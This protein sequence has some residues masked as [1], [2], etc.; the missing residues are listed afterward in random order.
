MREGWRKGVDRGATAGRGALAWVECARG[1]C[2]GSVEIKGVSQ[3]AVQVDCGQMERRRTLAVPADSA[4]EVLIRSKL[5][6]ALGATQEDHEDQGLQLTSGV[7]I[8]L[9]LS[10]ARSRMAEEKEGKTESRS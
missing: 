2:R 5:L 10:V 8:L 3:G 9:A 1:R 6:T 4:G 7:G